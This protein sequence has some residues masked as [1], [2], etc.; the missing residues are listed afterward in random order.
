MRENA[1]NYADEAAVPVWRELPELG[2]A[3]T[4]TLSEDIGNAAYDAIAQAYTDGL[5]AARK[6]ARKAIRKLR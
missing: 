6:A 3:W 4:D 5:K 1:T 2:E